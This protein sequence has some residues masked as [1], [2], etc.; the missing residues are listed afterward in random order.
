MRPIVTGR[1]ITRSFQLSRILFVAPVVFSLCLSSVS[2][3]RIPQSN[4]SRLVAQLA[5]KDGFLSVDR[6]QSRLDVSPSFTKRL[7]IP[8]ERA[9]KI[10][11]DD[12]DSQLAA[13]GRP[14]YSALSDSDKQLDDEGKLNDDLTNKLRTFSGNWSEYRARFNNWA[15]QDTSRN[16]LELTMPIL[17]NFFEGFSNE[18]SLTFDATDVTLWDGSTG[19]ATFTV[20]DP[21][22]DWNSDDYS[23]VLPDAATGG[24]ISNVE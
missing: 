15:T 20:V 23:V 11:Y 18:T 14:Y 22:D 19:R 3:A 13:L 8:I 16:P 9:R 6:E 4:A 10:L 24:T 2:S 12:L 17:V 1:L 21:I 7:K 5:I